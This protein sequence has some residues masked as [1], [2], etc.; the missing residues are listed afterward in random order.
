M[1]VSCAA[2]IGWKHR[3]RESGLNAQRHR[4]HADTPPARPPQVRAAGRQETAMRARRLLRE[5]R[6]LAKRERK[7][8]ITQNTEGSLILVVGGPQNSARNLAWVRGYT[9]LSVVLGISG[10]PQVSRCLTFCRHSAFCVG[11]ASKSLRWSTEA[12]L[13]ES[14]RHP[15]Y[16]Q[17]ARATIAV[18]TAPVC[19]FSPAPGAK[20]CSI[21]V[22][23]VRPSTGSTV[24]TRKYAKLSRRGLAQASQA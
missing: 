6:A 5:T 21:A 4:R 8:Y 15:Y 12:R 2:F 11:D 16:T 14:Q 17:A 23:T 20:P 3:A 19:P 24:G 10:W 1:R 22:G 13:P 7:Q 9:P 18:P